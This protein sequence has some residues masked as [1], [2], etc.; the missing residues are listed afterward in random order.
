VLIGTPDGFV[1]LWS[2]AEQKMLNAWKAGGSPIRSVSGSV[3]GTMAVSGAEDGSTYLWKMNQPAAVPLETS[4][5]ETFADGVRL[6]A[7]R[8]SLPAKT[9]GVTSESR[10][11]QNSYSLHAA[12][13]S[14]LKEMPVI[15]LAQFVSI[16]PSFL[17]TGV[18]A[19]R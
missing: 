2:L 4:A 12:L 14:L 6:A 7:I 19:V 8:K 10:K 11:C 18:P 3:D 5:G 15:S 16:M 1:Q 17:K 13:A 9:A